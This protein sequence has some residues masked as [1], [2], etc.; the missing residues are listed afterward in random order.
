MSGARPTLLLSFCLIAA[1][2]D[3]ATI[4]ARATQ[5]VALLQRVA[6]QW[7]TPCV[8][9]HHQA[10]P[11]LAL[12]AARSRGLEVSEPAA[13]SAAARTFQLLSGL[14]RAVQVND[15]IDP[16]LSEGYMLMGAHASGIAPNLS[17]AAYARHIARAQR[18]DGSW[19][20]FDNRPPHS[21]GLFVSTAVAARAAGLYL[22]RQRD[23]Q[24]NA[25]LERARRWLLS[26]KIESTEDATY[27]VFG[28][29]WTRATAAE[30]S[31]AARELYALQRADGGWA[32]VP[33]MTESDAYSTAQALTALSRTGAIRR[34]HPVFQRGVDWLIRTQAKDGSW[35]V[36]SRIQTPAPISPPYFESGFP[37]GHDQ[38]LSCAATAWAVMALTEALDPVRTPPK[39]LAVPEAAPVAQP[40]METALF[41]TADEV[42]KLDPSLATPG[43]TSVLMMAADDAAKVRA[44]LKRGANASAPAKSGVDALMVAALYRD[45]REAAELLIQAGA[46]AKPRDAVKY[47]ASPLPVAIFGG[48][49][50]MVKLLLD[51]GAEVERPMTLIGNF[52]ATPLTI[53]VGMDDAE[54]TRLLVAK[55]ANIEALD[56]FQMTQ[57]SWA[58][59][60][61]K[62]AA[63][64]ALLELGAKRG[65]KDKFGLTPIEHTRGIAHFGSVTEQILR[66]AK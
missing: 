43:G 17:T 3:E 63:L 33:S 50:A 52:P 39:P 40:W 51:H 20:T 5:S 27:R 34:D 38:V 44:L 12:D 4:R 22:P 59:L 35:H 57:V 45:N 42:A 62:N 64:R 15:I 54:L 1:A 60:G 26:A 66:T 7:K 61:H 56:E 65:V 14:D 48:D 10:M 41:G 16:S 47:K 24:R 6:A 30:Q 25:V 36:K 18:P 19:A 58:A 37:Y 49:A 8:S 9:C 28:L 31:A 13:R 46:S 11:A 55:G 53:A 2:A 21:A 23:A 29:Y 32:Q